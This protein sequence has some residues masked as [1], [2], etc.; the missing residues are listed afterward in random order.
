MI[1]G[2]D[3]QSIPLWR[4]ER[5]WRVALQ[6]GVLVVVI[7]IAS[8]LVH[9]VSVNL[10]RT[11]TEFGFGFLNTQAAFDIQ[12]SIIP[13]DPATDSYGR[14]L[15]AGFLNSLRVIIPGL[16]LTT[17]L[18]ILA[19]VVSFSDNWLLRKGSL[20]YVEIIRNI[21]LLLQ[22][23]FWY[24]AVFS[25]LPNP[26]NRLA[27]FGSIYL[28]NRGVFLPWPAM[29]WQFGSSAIALLV[30]V[31]A[32]GWLWRWRTQLMV[33][34]GQSGQSQLLALWAL[35]AIAL[36]LVVFG[37][38]WQIPQETD[39]AVF[40]GGLRL[41]AEFSAILFGLVIYT[42]AYVSEIVRAGIQSVAKGQW[43]AARAL[44]LKSG[45]T[46]R[47][48]VFPQALRVIIPPL[49]SQYMNLAKNSSLAIAVGYVDIYSVAN[50]TYNQAGRPVEVMLIIMVTY[51]ILDLM[52]SAVMNTLNNLVQIRER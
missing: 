7:A 13:Y 14:V 30:L 1:T 18:G 21:P 10:Q 24:R 28:S 40:D 5:F 46:M 52:I 49:N 38:G 31:I 22:L 12:E 41:S 35:A 17:L 44:G 19:G 51:L 34:T 32:V 26:D 50:T 39:S 45:L 3:E 37:F 33:E 25:K 47:L 2:N 27:W 8:L 36:L 43:E 23:Y 4:D 15:L 11:G 9:N 48:V 20:L 6:I 29:N 42:S 16:I